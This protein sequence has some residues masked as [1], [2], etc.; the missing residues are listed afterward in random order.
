[1]CVLAGFVCFIFISVVVL[2]G[3]FVDC[4]T[5]MFCGKRTLS[6]YRILTLSVVFKFL[7]SQLLMRAYNVP[8]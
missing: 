7:E 2:F 8:E 4:F 6:L 1:M 3:V 5:E